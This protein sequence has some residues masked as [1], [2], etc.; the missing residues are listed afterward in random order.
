[1]VLRSFRR[2]HA[3]VRASS[4][5]SEHVRAGSSVNL[6]APERFVEIVP[7]THVGSRD[8]NE[9]QIAPCCRCQYD[10][11]DHQTGCYQMLDAYVVMRTWASVDLRSRCLRGPRPRSSKWCPYAWHRPTPIPTEDHWQGVCRTHLQRCLHHLREGQVRLGD[12]LDIPSV[13]PPRYSGLN[14]EASAS[15]ALIGSRTRGITPG[16]SRAINL[17]IDPAGDFMMFILPLQGNLSFSLDLVA[18]GTCWRHDLARPQGCQFM[19]RP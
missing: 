18:A 13:R 14:P 2:S 9:V 8:D 16:V 12:D 15:F 6:A 1:M 3:P 10:L 19:V 11:F 5:G 4:A 7:P 17:R